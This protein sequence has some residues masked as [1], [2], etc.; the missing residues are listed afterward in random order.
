MAIRMHKKQSYFGAVTVLILLS[1]CLHTVAPVGTWDET[2]KFDFPGDQL[3]EFVVGVNCA[4][5]SRTGRLVVRDMQ[6]CDRMQE[7][8]ESLGAVVVR[9]EPPLLWSEDV[10][11]SLIYVSKESSRSISPL[12]ILAIPSLTLFPVVIDHNAVAEVLVKDSHGATQAGRTVSIGGRDFYGAGSLIMAGLRRMKSNKKI[13]ISSLF[14]KTIAN[15]ANNAM[16]RDAL[17][18]GEP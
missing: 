12:S 2:P 8:I 17:S 6:I 18:D 1:G 14:D 13:K 9:P 7:V 10:D 16:I 11:F 15:L 3:S 4:V 5:R